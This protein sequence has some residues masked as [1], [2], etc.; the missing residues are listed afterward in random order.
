[1]KN[2]LPFV[3]LLVMKPDLAYSFALSFSDVRC[4]EIVRTDFASFMDV[5]P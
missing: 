3:Y 1:M 5:H 2:K 4:V